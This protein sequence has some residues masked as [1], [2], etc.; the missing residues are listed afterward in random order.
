MKLYKKGNLCKYTGCGRAKITVSKSKGA[1][2]LVLTDN[3]HL[4]YR[5]AMLI[6]KSEEQ[7]YIIYKGEYCQTKVL[8]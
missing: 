5:A 8:T 4:F 7:Q 6:D 2:S 3:I 1:Y